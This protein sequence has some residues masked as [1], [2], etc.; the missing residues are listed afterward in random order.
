MTIVRPSGMMSLGNWI[1]LQS[2]PAKNQPATPAIIAVRKPG[3]KRGRIAAYY[4]TRNIPA[5]MSRTTNHG[6]SAPR[7]ALAIGGSR[8]IASAMG[9]FTTTPY[10]NTSPTLITA[11]AIKPPIS[12]FLTSILPIIQGS[13]I[14]EGNRIGPPISI[15]S[16]A[17]SACHAAPSQSLD[18]I[19][20]CARCASPDT[21]PQT[22]GAHHRIPLPAPEG[23][24]ERREVR[25]RSVD[26]PPRGGV[27]VPVDL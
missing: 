10:S 9:A 15:P 2:K 24:R 7:H 3:P 4:H 12:T 18:G 5:T 27:R 25:Q 6:T 26:P 20:S 16:T 23:G 14:V 19:P 11:P 22:R 17:A 1:K 8:C 21:P 13:V